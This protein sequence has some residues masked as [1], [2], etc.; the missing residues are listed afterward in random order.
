MPD[1]FRADRI[2]QLATRSTALTT[3]L[4]RASAESSVHEPQELIDLA[5]TAKELS[6]SLKNVRSALDGDKHSLPSRASF[7]ALELVIG[8]ANEVYDG[9][10]FSLNSPSRNDAPGP[11]DIADGL[12]LSCGPLSKANCLLKSLEALKW[13]LS[14]ITHA[15]I[16]AKVINTVQAPLMEKTAEPVATVRADLESIV[17]EQQLALLRA[18]Q[19]WERFD[20]ALHEYLDS[21]DDIDFPFPPRSDDRSV[22]PLSTG[23]KSPREAHIAS[24]LSFQEESLRNTKVP[25]SETECVVLVLDVYVSHTDDVL[26][27]WTCLT[28]IEHR[29]R[30]HMNRKSSHQDSA[31]DA[32][33]RSQQPTV[34][35][36]DE[37]TL[38]LEESRSRKKSGVISP[39]MS[40]VPQRP[41]PSAE[42]LASR[43]VPPIEIPKTVPETTAPPPLMPNGQPAQVNMASSPTS[44]RYSPASNRS[45]HSVSQS[46][47]SSTQISPRSSISSVTPSVGPPVVHKPASRIQ[48]DEDVY[49]L[50]RPWR[51]CA[52]DMYWDFVNDVCLGRNTKAHH[53]VAYSHRR[54][55]TEIMEE[56]ICREALKEAGLEFQRVTKMGMDPRRT[57]T[58]GSGCYCIYR[59]LTYEQVKALID[60]SVEIIADKRARKASCSLTSRSSRGLPRGFSSPNIPTHPI[61]IPQAA[62]PRRESSDHLPQS[63]QHATPPQPGLSPYSPTHHLQG[64]QYSPTTSHHPLSRSWSHP[65]AQSASQQQPQQQQQQH[66]S[67]TTAAAPAQG[68]PPATSAAQAPKTAP[69]PPSPSSSGVPTPRASSTNR[70]NSSSRQA[71][72][73]SSAAGTAASH[74]HQHQR[75]GYA[76]R[77]SERGRET[78]PSSSSDSASGSEWDAWSDEQPRD[79]D[80]ERERERE[81]D[82]EREREWRHRHRERRPSKRDSRT[83]SYE[84]HAYDDREKERDGRR[85]RDRDRTR[86]RDRHRRRSSMLTTIGQIAGATAL[87]NGLDL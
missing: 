86:D 52:G 40:P 2:R 48:E 56:W 42:S 39:L 65:T 38:E 77:G 84:G 73:A 66:F 1:V 62:A 29:V 71:S 24:L 8:Q 13:T 11:S 37:S 18:R 36:D 79:R 17:I 4:Y 85:D 5:R 43:V 51:L 74:Q 58:E 45:Y 14:V 87:L 28:E 31:A 44:S 15:L 82:R 55:Y 70:P 76:R 72:F 7:D 30:E 78:P 67:P 33:R 81:R 57:R 83:S 21:I 32:R 26:R 49:Q 6:G 64:P 50:D 22:S 25:P 10:E 41:G 19:A 54:A 80:R 68:P 75:P 27:R 23:S 3:K 53:S 59:A 16:T 34:E 20:D 9:I 63:R 47:S 46:T 60:R 61:D 69:P 12:D 35:T